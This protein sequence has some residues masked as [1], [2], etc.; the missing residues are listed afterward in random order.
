[1]KEEYKSIHEFEFQLICDF[2]KEL[3]RQGP[4]SPEVTKKALSFIER[5]PKDAKI[6]DLGCGSGGQTI[7]LAE[8]TQGH[9]TAIDLFPA[10]IERLKIMQQQSTWKTESPQWLALWENFLSRKMKWT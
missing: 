3:D 6:A 9:I 2:F 10:F 5:L 7:V 8:N 4:G 1:M